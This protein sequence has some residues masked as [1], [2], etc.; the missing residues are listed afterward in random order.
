[1]L[2]HEEK[3]L[4]FLLNYLLVLCKLL[5]YEAH[6]N[7]YFPSPSKY[8]NLGTKIV[9]LR[10][11]SHNNSLVLLVT[12]SLIFNFVISAKSGNTQIF[13]HSRSRVPVLLPI[14]STILFLVE[15]GEQFSQRAKTTNTSL[16]TR[17]IL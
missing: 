9:K 7:C 13:L 14:L 4:V 11:K 8:L 16:S 5:L 3:Q 6:K 1:M 17:D 12:K 2:T 15:R 10:R